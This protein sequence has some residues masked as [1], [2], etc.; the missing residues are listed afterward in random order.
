MVKIDGKQCTERQQRQARGMA[1]ANKDLVFLP[2][3]SRP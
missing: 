3:L 2:N 1:A